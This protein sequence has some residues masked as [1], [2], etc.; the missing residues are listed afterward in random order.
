ML[1]TEETCAGQADKPRA[2]VHK[3]WMPEGMGNEHLHKLWV[4]ERTEPP[5]NECK[6]PQQPQAWMTLNGWIRV[7]TNDGMHK[8]CSSRGSETRNC[9]ALTAAI[10]AASV[11]GAARH[12]YVRWEQ[13]W[14]EGTHKAGMAA[15][16]GRLCIQE[17]DWVQSMNEG[18]GAWMRVGETRTGTHWG[19][20]NRGWGAQKRATP[21]NLAYQTT[22]QGV[23]HIS[24][25]AHSLLW[26]H[27]EPR[28]VGKGKLSSLFPINYLVHNYLANL[29]KWMGETTGLANT[30]GFE[31]H[32]TCNLQILYPCCYGYGVCR[33]RCGVTKSHPLCVTPY[34]QNY[35]CEYKR[36][37]LVSGIF[38][39]S[40]WHK[41]HWGDWGAGDI[42][43]SKSLP[44]THP[45]L[46]PPC[47]NWKQI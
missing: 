24:Q 18:W 22:L 41:S 37:P 12:V 43:V 4:S 28:L 6:Q 7:C 15:V 13:Q 29:I 25:H 46:Q 39:K 33:C 8:D 26:G 3:W 14:P 5:L 20:T 45:P 32:R 27:L 9:G 35:P 36:L 40:P 44:P 47:N 10:A 38:G 17:Q 34:Q 21:Y 2:R 16:G 1:Q 23:C 30:A 42:S 31:Q 19:S 11:A